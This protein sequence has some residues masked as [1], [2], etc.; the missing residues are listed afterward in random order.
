MTEINHPM[1]DKIQ[2][3]LG[4]CTSIIDQGAKPLAVLSA[5]IYII[6]YLVTSYHLSKYGVPI[7]NLI[8]AQ[9]FAA[10]LLP[11]ILFWVTMA[12]IFSSW[13]F[14]PRIID[15]NNK[16]KPIW[17]SANILAVILIVIL[18]LMPPQKWIELF[19][20]GLL[21]IFLLGEL[22]IW[23][24]IVFIPRELIK[25]WEFEASDIK[26]K[27]SKCKGFFVLFF[28]CFALIIYI[29]V[30]LVIAVYTL[31][32]I[33]FSGPIFYEQLPQA[34]GGGKLQPVQLYVDSQKI[35][36]EL[37]DAN[38]SLV[39]GLPARTIPMYLIYQTSTEYIVR[40]INGID[41]RVW[42]LKP[43]AVYAIVEKP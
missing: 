5:T 6:G 14:N 43:D 10:G 15:Q 39:Q 42:T 19:P 29:I 1:I 2:K 8:D 9:Y 17:I 18:K 26:I 36:S 4:C 34:Y 11:G 20:M 21:F 3:V 13:M 37:L 25:W 33:Q 41:Q 30:L 23:I 35:P 28:K 16:A 38:V 22:S 7:K 27:T 12:V 31:V 32:Y 24:F 40:P